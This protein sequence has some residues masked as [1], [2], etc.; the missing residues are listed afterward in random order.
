MA[1]NEFA[2]IRYGEIRRGSKNFSSR[3]Y[4]VDRKPMKELKM[5]KVGR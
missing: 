5:E 1:N 3:K 4:K 2:K